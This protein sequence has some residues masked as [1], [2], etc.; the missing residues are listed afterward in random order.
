MTN[1]TRVIQD[2]KDSLITF[3][4]ELIDQFPLE[5]DLIAARIIIK[6]KISG[7]KCINTF[8][9]DIMP[10]KNEIKNRNENFFLDP[11]MPLFNNFDFVEVDKN[12]IN[13]FTVLWKSST[14]DNE[15]KEIIWNWF[16]AFILYAEQ[17]QKLK[18][19]DI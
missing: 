11:N 4:D 12:K 7:E 14:L 10:Y 13:H 15:D 18:I 3:L 5:A 16:D 6:S 19:L 2:F 8:I 1:I 17:Y 9:K